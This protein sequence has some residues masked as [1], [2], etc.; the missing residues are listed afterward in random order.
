MLISLYYI[1][2][3]QL[4]VYK[5]H[6]IINHDVFRKVYK[7]YIYLKNS[8][9]LLK[10]LL[11]YL[12]I[13]RNIFEMAI[14]FNCSVLSDTFNDTFSVNIFRENGNL[15]AKFGNEIYP[16][17]SFK[18][19]NLKGYICKRRDVADSNKHT[20]KLWKVN[21][22]TE[23]VSIREE[24]FNDEMIPQKLFRRYYDSEIGNHDPE[25]THIIAIIPA[26]G[27]CLP[28]FYLSN[29]RFAV[30]KYRVCSDLFFSR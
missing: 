14:S 13:Y 10:L 1:S 7:V 28:T 3:H 23:E 26:T 16:F 20:V 22:D 8:S 25:K 30:T 6:F 24:L 5:D 15:F 21:V 4:R 29:K 11:T 18:V 2:C 19:D 17:E 12:L 27:K 9:K